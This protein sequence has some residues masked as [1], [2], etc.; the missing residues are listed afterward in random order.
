[1]KESKKE[2]MLREKEEEENKGKEESKLGV[3][4]KTGFICEFLPVCWGQKVADERLQ[5]KMT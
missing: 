5:H 1:M 3:Q 4:R 2:T